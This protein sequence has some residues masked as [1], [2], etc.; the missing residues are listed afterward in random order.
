MKN[1][2]SHPERSLA[3]RSLTPRS[4][5]AAGALSALASGITLSGCDGGG[6]EDTG[7]GGSVASGGS[8][9]GG[10][11][12]GGAAATGGSDALGGGGHGGEGG[13]GGESGDPEPPVDETVHE[14]SRSVATSEFGLQLDNS[15]VYFVPICELDYP[16]R[17]VRI[18]GLLASL[19]HGSGQLL[20]GAA[21]APTASNPTTTGSQ[22]K[23][24]AYGGS[25]P[26]PP[27]MVYAN[28][29][30]STVTLDPA[31][32]W[33]RTSS[34]VCLD[35]FP[36]TESS[37]ARVVLWR[38]GVDGSGGEALAD[39]DDA[40]SLTL[41]NAAL[42]SIGN[43][44]PVGAVEIDGPVY[45]RHTGQAATVSLGDVTALDASELPAYVPPAVAA[46]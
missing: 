46:P 24:T 12:T 35:L 20:F 29:G 1:P 7:G 34:T 28:Y 17:H 31:A 25:N 2:A 40:Q 37:P 38:D 42:D 41:A 27:A 19:G 44:L 43:E 13:Q 8:A 10:Q 3:Q 33:V 16:V 4:L 26:A 5:L 23:L 22:L 6:S 18:D 14:C 30:A 32:V 15:T 9:S 21:S 11:S 45:F 36:A 39:C